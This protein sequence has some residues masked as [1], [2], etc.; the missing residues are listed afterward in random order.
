MGRVNKQRST[1]IRQI[2]KILLQKTLTIER[3]KY[4]L[5]HG[6]H[7]IPAGQSMAKAHFQHRV[8]YYCPKS[9]D[10]LTFH[11][12]SLPLEIALAIKTTNV[13]KSGHKA[14]SCHPVSN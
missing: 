8:N 7:P 5:L 2:T 1:E 11:L 14:H 3:Y 10:S 9:D 6:C 12:A 4:T 13:H